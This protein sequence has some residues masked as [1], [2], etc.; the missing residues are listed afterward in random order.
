MPRTMVIFRK[1]GVAI[2]PAP[3][4]FVAVPRR[5]PWLLRWI[6]DVSAL[7]GSSRALKEYVGL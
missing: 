5:G 6:P 1:Q 3:T 7:D 4:H 2:I